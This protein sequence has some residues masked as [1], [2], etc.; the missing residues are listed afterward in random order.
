MGMEWLGWAMAVGVALALACMRVVAQYERGVVLRWGKL[1]RV[2]EPGLHFLIPGVDRL[3]RVSTRVTVMDVPKQDVITRDNVPI[4]VNAVV[5]F[6]VRSPQDAVMEVEN[7][8]QAT[9][10]KA[11]TTLREVVG[12]CEL[13]E[14][15]SSREKVNEELKGVIGGTVENWGIEVLGVEVKDVEL[16]EGMQRAMARQAEAERER[17]AKIIGAEGEFEAAARLVEAARRMEQH[18]VAVQLRFLQTLVE[19]ASEK[20]STIVLPVPLELLEG[21]VRRRGEGG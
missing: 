19:V 14:L 12:R 6:R 2:W 16:P 11:Q 5:F 17:R 1:W 8:V 3:H 13:D 7:F 4:R 20:N 9:S 10:Q 15:L 21:W 18:P